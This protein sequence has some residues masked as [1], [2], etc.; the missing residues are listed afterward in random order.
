MADRLEFSFV[1]LAKIASTGVITVDVDDP[2]DQEE[3]SKKLKEKNFASFVF[4]AHEPE[5][6]NWQF[7]PI[8]EAPIANDD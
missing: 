1:R 3:I 7:Y 5:E 2:F 6:E 4:T 8:V